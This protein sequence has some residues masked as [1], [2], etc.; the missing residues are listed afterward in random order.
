MTTSQTALY[1]SDEQITQLVRA[2]ENGTL[3][4]DQFNHHAHITVALWY[5]SQMPFEEAMTS[6]RT[7]VHYFAVRHHLHNQIYHETITGFWMR[8]LRH[9][10]DRADA[11]EAFPDI[12]Y[13]V[14]TTYGTMH[15][16]FRHYSK[17]RAFSP[18]AR[19][20]WVEPDLIPL[21]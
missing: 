16:F 4:A 13:R 12:V 11:N 9:M 1:R 21:P 10:L 14:L 17:E 8:L 7:S 5:L 19:N 18:E 3:T 20:L 15:F 2:F 6:M